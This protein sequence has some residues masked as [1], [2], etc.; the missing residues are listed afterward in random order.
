MEEIKDFIIS[1]CELIA[2]FTFIYI[3]VAVACKAINHHLRKTT[4]ANLKLV[5]DKEGIKSILGQ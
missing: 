5:I 2:I 4:Q 1:A 3:S